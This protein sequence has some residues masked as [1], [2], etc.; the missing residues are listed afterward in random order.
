MGRKREVNGDPKLLP[1]MAHM[2]HGLFVNM[3]LG[4]PASIRI[5]S[6]SHVDCDRGMSESAFSDPRNSVI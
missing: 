3:V 1:S 2:Q 6:A 4:I 5:R